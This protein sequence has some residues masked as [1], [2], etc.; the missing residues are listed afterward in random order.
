MAIATIEASAVLVEEI[1]AASLSEVSNMESDAAQCTH[2]DKKERC[3]ESN[4]WGPSQPQ[5]MNS[6]D[7]LEIIEE[8]S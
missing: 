5:E 2:N 3:N 4:R 1:L 7:A 8:G 6:F